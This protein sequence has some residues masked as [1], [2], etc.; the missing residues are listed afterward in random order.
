MSQWVKA[1]QDVAVNKEYSQIEI[2]VGVGNMNG[3]VMAVLREPV[4]FSTDPTSVEARA[5]LCA[6]LLCQEL[7]LDHVLFE[8]DA[9]LVVEAIGKPH[10]NFTRYG[11]IVEE[12]KQVLGGFKAWNL[13]YI[14]S[15]FNQVAHVLA[16]DAVLYNTKCIDRVTSHVVWTYLV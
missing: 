7:G 13:R 1:N 8:G 14:N 2:G 12:I 16:K 10:E 15:D 11:R 9:K 6:G 5:A 3:E 4:I